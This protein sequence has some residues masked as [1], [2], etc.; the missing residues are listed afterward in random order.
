MR[1][2]HQGRLDLVEALLNAGAVVDTPSVAL[3]TALSHAVSE[4]HL[5]VAQRLINA[6]ADVNH[7]NGHQQTSQFMVAVKKGNLSMMNLLVSN[8]A[9]VNY[10]TP[11]EGVTAIFI[12][13]ESGRR[14]L[15][16]C[17]MIYS[18]NLDPVL[19]ING[20]TPLLHAAE[21]GHI[22][23]VDLLLQSKVGLELTDRGGRTALTVAAQNGR[24]LLVDYLIGR[25]ANVNNVIPGGITTISLAA[26]C[27]YARV[28]ESLILAGAVFYGTPASDPAI[29]RA[30][31]GGSASVVSLLLQYKAP[32]D[33]PCRR[34]Q[35]TAL[36]VASASGHLEVVQVLIA[37][38]ANLNS[39]N[40]SY[41][42]P[43]FN[44]LLNKHYAVVEALVFAGA[45]TS[46]VEVEV[47]GSQGKALKGILEKY[48]RHMQ[49]VEASAAIPVAPYVSSTSTDQ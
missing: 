49:A 9:H 30:A 15:V 36:C 3:T 29:I 25:G 12:A 13:A 43:I 38:K 2:A 27:R 20:L 7:K 39:V 42:S 35:R 23:V 34:Q 26:S 17:L 16:E 24:S 31:A 6:G 48:K 4:G 21:L 32:V 37:N 5:V 44:A 18:A 10:A 40:H 33:E 8:N 19:R 1:A 46:R 41:R 14:D 11:R 22:A 47:R 45:D 28:V